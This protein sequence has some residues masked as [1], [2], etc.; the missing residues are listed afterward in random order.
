MHT[1][2]ID[3]APRA[4][5][6]ARS[7][8]SEAASA[9]ERALAI[10]TSYFNFTDNPWMERNARCALANWKA[11]G[12][13]TVLV[14]LARS[15]TAFVFDDASADKVV[16]IEVQDVMWYKENAVNVGLAAVPTACSVVCWAD[17]DVLV[18]HVRHPRWAQ[19]LV[20]CVHDSGAHFVQGFSRVH[21]LSP[22]RRGR[23]R[24]RRRPA[25]AAAG[26]PG[27]GRSQRGR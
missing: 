10:V 26:R 13:F 25:R 6:A 4:V 3:Q 17:S 1:E 27:D 11:T 12:A 20:R 24:R 9:H 23:R 8:A 2:T 5:P 18:D 19:D 16:Q 21:K 14:E 7:D 15:K 22:G